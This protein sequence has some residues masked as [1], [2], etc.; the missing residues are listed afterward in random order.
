MTQAITATYRNHLVRM[1][2][3]DDAEASR[4][5]RA[6]L[7]QH[8]LTWTTKKSNAR[9][10]AAMARAHPDRLPAMFAEPRTRTIINR[11]PTKVGAAALLRA[12]RRKT[13]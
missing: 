12:K 3:C 13:P 11:S 8:G 4:A 2:Q 7:T 6:E 10:N 5:A 9:T 1:A